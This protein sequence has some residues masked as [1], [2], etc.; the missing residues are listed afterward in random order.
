MHDDH[1]HGDAPTRP[2]G[3]TC[4]GAPGEDHSQ[5][6]VC[7]PQ[8]YAKNIAITEKRSFDFSNFL[9]GMEVYV[10]LCPA[11]CV[12]AYSRLRLCVRVHARTMS[13]GQLLRFFVWNALPSDE[14]P[15]QDFVES[16]SL[17]TTDITSTTT[18][19]ALVTSSVVSDPG[20]YVKLSLRATQVSSFTP[21]TATLSVSMLLRRD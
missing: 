10:V 12:L 19:P 2:P 20:A 3:C 18:A 16:S 14:D 5:C 7:G 21:F 13:S 17:I 8:P 6:P 15:G 9:S 4:S 11:L 1:H